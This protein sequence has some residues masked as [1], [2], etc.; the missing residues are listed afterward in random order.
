PLHSAWRRPRPE[1]DGLP[2]PD[3]DHGHRWTMAW[4]S[5]DFCRVGFLPGAVAGRP[6]PGPAM[7]RPH[8]AGDP[9]RPRC[10][11]GR[12]DLRDLPPRLPGVAIL[13]SQFIGTGVGHAWCYRA[14]FRATRP[15]D[16][17]S[18]RRLCRAVALDSVAPIPHERP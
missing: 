1:M 6:S 3:A 7:A 5:V 16:T 13:P 11:D 14:S 8:P 12:A 4:R 15:V 10:V 17:H 9:G 18:D 2:Q